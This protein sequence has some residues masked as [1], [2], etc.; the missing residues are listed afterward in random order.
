[1]ALDTVQITSRILEYVPK[2]AGI[3]RIEYEGPSIAIYSRNPSVL[4]YHGYILTEIANKLKKRV[5]ARS[6]P[7]ERMPTDE[8]RSKIGEVMKPHSEVSGMYFD[9]VKG[10]VILYLEETLEPILFPEI[11]VK[12]VS[13]TRWFPVFRKHFEPFS[14]TLVGIYS[15]NSYYE[16]ERRRFLLGLG[17]RIFR[18][19]LKPSRDIS[20]TVLGGAQ[21]VGRSAALFS[22][23]ETKLLVDFGLK[24]GVNERLNSYPRIDAEDFNI[25]ELDGIIVTHA[26]LDHS[27][28]VPFLYKHGYDGPLYMTEPTLPLSV[29]LQLDLIQVAQRNGEVPPYSPTDVRKMIYQ[30]VQLKY[31]QVTDISPDVKL[32]FYNAGHVLGS[33]VSHL[34]IVEGVHN[35]VFTGDFKY[36]PTFLLDSAYSNFLRAETVVMESTYGGEEDVTPSRAEAE[37]ALLENVNRVLE[38]DG[39]VLMPTLAVGRAQEI[40]VH[41]EKFL[42]EK[43]MMEVPIYI[44]G[45][46]D[47]STAI[48]VSYPEY[49][50]SKLRKMILDQGINPFSSEHF[51]IV[52]DPSLRE[53]ALGKGPC[54]IVST[55][56]MLEGGPVLEYLKYV[57]GDE[58]NM[59]LFSS[60]QVS[61]TLGRRI[62]NGTKNIIMT[63]GDKMQTIEIKAEIRRIEGFSGHSDR[64]QLIS[65]IKKISPMTK[66]LFLVHGEPEKSLSLAKAAKRMVHGNVW[67]LRNLQTVPLTR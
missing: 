62:L 23:S 39:K 28:M 13:N 27:G 4:L 14:K 33:A 26:H 32:T 66:N 51:V 38:R 41:F 6:E 24:P 8:A 34:H 31:G 49:L 7:S 15:A 67:P 9:P 40:L 35:V 12:I 37:K 46:I 60:Y 11:S 48:H 56:G 18:K 3:T 5:I 47:E 53:E 2:E 57:A 42:R 54:I 43:K 29:L 16:K 45:M 30:T 58:R 21:E 44:D 20:I 50:S 61:G 1:M 59:I 25:D 36:G 63:R 19:P 64:R 17:D 52:D 65:Y 10:E 22:T 55:S